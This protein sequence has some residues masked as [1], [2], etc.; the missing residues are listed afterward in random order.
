MAIGLENFPNIEAPDGDFPTGRIQDKT[1]SENGKPA[2]QETVDDIFQ[3]FAKLL[4]ES[5]IVAYVLPESEYAVHQ[6]L[7][8]LQAIINSEIDLAS[9]IEWTDITSFGTDWSAGSDTPQ[10][11]KD[12]FGFVHLRGKITHSGSITGSDTTTIA[13]LPAAGFYPN[14]QAFIVCGFN[15]SGVVQSSSVHIKIGGTLHVPNN[16]SASVTIDLN[17]IGSFYAG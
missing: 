9:V 6:Y 7:E 5:S 3:F 17:L 11:C 15:E 4:R 16:L 8:A 1:S 14:K 13:T 2:N 12:I 10:V